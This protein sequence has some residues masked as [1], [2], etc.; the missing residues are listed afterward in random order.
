[1]SEA[2]H[3]QNSPVTHKWKRYPKYKDSG[4]EWLG[5]VPEEWQLKKAKWLFKEIVDRDHPEEP[6]LSVTQQNGIVTREES[7]INVWNPTENVSGYKLVKKGEFVISLRSF[8]GG[9]EYSSIQGIVSPAYI[10]VRKKNAVCD[11]YFRF[12]FKSE[13]FISML[14]ISTT[15]IRQGKNI[16]YED[17]SLIVCPTVPRENCE[18]IAS[19]LNRVTSRIDTLIAKKERQIELLQEIQA[20]FINHAVTK[21][22][23]PNVRMKESGIEWIELIPAHWQ[24]AKLAAIS[25]EIG[26]G[27]HG[28]PQYT[29]KSPYYFINGNNLS[30][31]SITIT[32]SARCISAGEFEKYKV[33]LDDSTILM[34]ING[35]IG[36]VA[37]YRGESIILGKS[38]AY[39]NSGKSI[40]R[41]YLFFLLQS[42]SIANYLR[43][44]ATG[45]TIF[46]LS[47][48]TIRKLQVPLPPLAEQEK[49]S[50]FIN[51]ES[52]RI[53]AVV[54][55]IQSSIEVLRKYRIA[56]ISATVTGKIDVRQEISA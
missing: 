16:G 9:I 51:T 25:T 55:K 32:E 18:A 26:D 6:L 17:F 30:N 56:L 4:V 27:L 2:S 8:Q 28:T 13:P 14:D 54:E 42:A 21:G 35:T 46:N 10:V 15:G 31:G 49:I 50:S 40:S 38:A 34:S 12:L 37:Y 52:S 43:N 41:N 3:Q 39:I 20:A 23:D 22:L 24:K 53:T 36:S 48:E 5:E 44:Q 7:D 45:T 29:E 19:F 11:N 47:L 1:M 33:L